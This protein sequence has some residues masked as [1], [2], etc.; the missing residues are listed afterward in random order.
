LAQKCYDHPD[1]K[2]GQWS[3]Y[4]YNTANNRVLI[5]L[6]SEKTLI[7]ASNLKIIT[8]AAALNLLGEDEVFNTYLEYSGNIN[9]KGELN[10]NI[11]LRGEGDPT[12]GSSQM[13]GVLRLDSLYQLW[14][15]QIKNINIQTINGQII[16]DDSYLDFMPIPGEWSWLD[17]GNYYAPPTSGLCINENMYSLVFTSADNLYITAEV[18]RTEPVIPGLSF[19]NMMK[20]G[21]VKNGANAFIYGAPGQWEQT[22]AGFIPAGRGEYAIEG[23]LP[24]PA[25]FSARYLKL[26][27]EQAGIKVNGPAS[28]I[29]NLPLS[30][31]KR[32]I[33]G[34]IKSPPLKKIIYRLNK[35]SVNLYAEQIVKILAKK[36]KGSGNLE[37]GLALVMAWLRDK[38]ISTSGIFILDGCGLSRSN[39]CTTRFIAEVLKVMN[40]EKQFAAF[41]DSLPIAGNANDPGNLKNMGKGTTAEGNIHAKTG[42]MDRVRCISGYVHS[43]S[44]EL[45]CFSI[46]ANN[47]IGSSKIIERLHESIVVSLAEMQ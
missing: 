29:K 40:K 34:I 38:D 31:E 3:V 42:S 19:F 7:P 4:A 45:I 18:S 22:L 10:G 26:K 8:S 46:M 12:L 23:S 2:Y 5:D 14:I 36:I 35:C 17:I 16:G 44:K 15:S 24:D 6:N 27:L 28:V 21:K 30:N 37:K 33:I 9:H 20:T 11:Y 13:N 43:R 32:K 25:L 41:Y 1:L 39:G 47:Y